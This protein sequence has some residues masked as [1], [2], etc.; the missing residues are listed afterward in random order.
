M[1]KFYC[2]YC[3]QINKLPRVKDPKRC[4]FCGNR[5]GFKPVRKLYGR[6]TKIKNNIN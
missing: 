5:Y 2:E 4:P 1:K 3:K 6:Y